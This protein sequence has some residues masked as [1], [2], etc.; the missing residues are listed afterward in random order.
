MSMSDKSVP[1]DY[2]EKHMVPKMVLKI[3][4]TNR[5]NLGILFILRTWSRVFVLR[6]RC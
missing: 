5:I 3:G 2:K 4:G 1:K 6:D